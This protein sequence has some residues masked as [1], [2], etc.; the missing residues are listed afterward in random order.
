MLLVT[1][2]FWWGICSIIFRVCGV[3][4]IFHLFPLEITDNVVSLQTIK[5]RN[6]MA[7]TSPLPPLSLRRSGEKSAPAEGALCTNLANGNVGN[8][9]SNVQEGTTA[10]TLYVWGC[11]PNFTLRFFLR[12]PFG[13]G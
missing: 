2:Y 5:S 7:G 9:H 13:T 11:G 4:H 1:C 8:F 10:F 12:P 3:K 6:K